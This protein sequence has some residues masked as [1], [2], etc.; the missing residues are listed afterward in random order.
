MMTKHSFTISLL[1]ICVPIM[2]TISMSTTPNST[3]DSNLGMISVSTMSP[4]D[5]TSLSSATTTHLG[6]SLNHG[7]TPSE[8]ISMTAWQKNTSSS[9]YISMTEKDCGTAL[10]PVFS[11]HSLCLYSA[12]TLLCI[13]SQK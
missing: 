1:L 6:S 3:E 11:T 2:G 10:K 4:E 9:P 8:L 13:L 5:T 7:T 12:L